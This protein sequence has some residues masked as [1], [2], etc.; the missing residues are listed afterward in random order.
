MALTGLEIYKQLPKTN[1]GKCGSPTCLAFAMQLS[2]K[3]TSLDK[4]PDISVEAK[5]ALEGAS[6]PPIRLISIGAGDNKLEVGNETVMFRHEQTFFHPCGLGVEIK[7][8]VQGA[9]LEAGIEKINKLC[10]E[11]VGQTIKVELICVRNESNDAQKFASCVEQIQAKTKLALVLASDK[12]EVIEAALKVCASAKPLIHAANASNLEAMV[13]LAKE[14]NCP[15]AVKGKGLDEL[16]TLTPRITAAGV[17][18]IVLDAASADPLETI[19]DLVHIRRLALKKNFRPLGYPVIVFTDAGDPQEE[20]MQAVSYISKYAGI[21]ILT[22]DEP[23]QA[24]P[25]VTL[26]QNLYTDPQKPIQVEAKVYEIGKVNVDSPVIVTT[27]FSLTYFTVEGEVEAGKIGTYVV[28]VDTEGQSVLTAFAADKLTAEGTAK[29]LNES[30]LAEKLNHKKVII[31]GY[32]SV[33]SGKLQEESGWEVL[34][35]P[36]E[37]S[38]LP[39]Y[40]RNVWQS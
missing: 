8:T 4:C 29:M 3:K 33:M 32:I 38:A 10:F 13:K 15:L 21:V 34:V 30:A 27:N 31:P 24:L 20:V 17:E 23:W 12:A 1:C 40:M 14:H 35:G 16:S 2:A 18:D 36:R 37:A 5:A 22:G 11:R 26:R 6:A 28:V 7:D 19:S 25:L 39:A 9:D